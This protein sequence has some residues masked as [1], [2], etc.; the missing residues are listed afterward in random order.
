MPSPSIAVLDPASD[1]NHEELARLTKLYTFPGF[2]KKADIDLTMNPKNIA[3]TAYADPVGKKFPC[4]TAAATWLSG[5]Y[6]QEKQ[7]EYHPKDRTQIEKRLQQSVEYFK[8]N[9]DYT[10]MCKQAEDLQKTA[11][12]PDSAYAYVWVDENGSKEKHLP[13]RSAMET[14]AAADWLE[15][16]KEKLPFHDRNTIAN[17]V[18]EKAAQ[19]GAGISNT[20]FLERQAG[21]GVC[22]PTEVVKM[23]RQRS[24]FCKTAE[25]KEAIELLA[26]S[27]ETQPRAALQD[28]RMIKL[29]VTMDLTDKALRIQDGYGDIL[30]RPEDVI[31]KATFTKSASDVA[32]LCALTTGNVY[33]KEQFEKLSRD[34]VEALFGTDFAD[35]VSSGLKV[36]GE[37]MAELAHTLPRPDAE[38]L[39]G[40]MADANLRPQMSKAASDGHQFSNEQLEELVAAFEN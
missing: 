20:D 13:M 10:T 16:H 2:V 8:I 11:E 18:L 26:K 4:H 30:Q 17:K 22:D 3:V 31:F 23:I 28:N 5:L 19:F 1:S 15:E 9:G 25:H 29:A 21:Q 36:D 35:E 39:E 32:E 12:L 33:S 24:S 37:K 40:L 27:V 38:L 7:A 14:K 6:F 34:N